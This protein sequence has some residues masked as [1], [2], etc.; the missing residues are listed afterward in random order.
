MVMLLQTQINIILAILLIILL[1]HAYFNINRKI[2]NR[3]VIC[4]MELV[5]FTLIL[6]TFSVLLNNSDLKQFM[7]LHKLVNIIGFIVAPII[8]FLGYI[9]SKEWINYYTDV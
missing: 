2:T 9:F 1:I 7:V 3:L 5:C 4:V 8:L 6:E